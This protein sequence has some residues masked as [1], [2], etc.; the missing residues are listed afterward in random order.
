[1]VGRCPDDDQRADAGGAQPRLEIGADEGA[2]DGLHQ[3]GLA[4]LLAGAGHRRV[5]GL[6]GREPRGGV[7]R[8]VADV[9]HGSAGGAEGG[10]EIGDARFGPRIVAPLARGLAL[11]EGLLD[12]DQEEGGGVVGEAHGGS[13]E[14]DDL[15]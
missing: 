15:R 3:D 6:A 14:T 11:G 13:P 10:E 12:V 4:G 7:R 2:V 1:M 8:G 9:D 5:A